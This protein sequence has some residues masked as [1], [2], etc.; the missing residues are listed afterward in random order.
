MRWPVSPIR[1]LQP[2]LLCVV[3]GGLP[4]RGGSAS[5]LGSMGCAARCIVWRVERCRKAV[6]ADSGQRG[7]GSRIGLKR[8]HGKKKLWGRDGEGLTAFS[9]AP[10]QGT[11]NESVAAREKVEKFSEREKERQTQKMRER[12]RQA[13]RK[14]ERP[15]TDD[16]HVMREKRRR[17]GWWCGEKPR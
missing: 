2:L 1:F 5:V 9:L 4:G 15:R 3:G 12:E 17:L 13:R 11:G 16:E 7:G 10:V 8:I 6:V 14:R